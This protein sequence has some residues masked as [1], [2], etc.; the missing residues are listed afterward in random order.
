MSSLIHIVRERFAR[1]SAMHSDHR[2]GLFGVGWSTLAQLVGM[3]LRLGSSLVLTRLLGQEVY[4]LF[5]PA[6]A[7]LMVVELISDLG[8]RP[9]LVRHSEGATPSWL[10]TGWVVTFLRGVCLTVLILGTSQILPGQLDKPDLEIILLVLAVRPMLQ[11]LYNSSLPV[12]YREMDFRAISIIEIAQTVAG[13]VTT[14]T[15]AWA[16]GERTVWAMVGGVFASDIAGLVAGYLLAPAPVRPHWNRGALRE[17]SSFGRAIY[18]NTMV[19]ALWLYFDRIVGLRYVSERDLGPYILAWNLVEVLDR[20][21]NRGCDVYYS[22]LSRA[23]SL[24]T[25]L[26]LH[27]T[28]S[29]IVSRVAMPLFAF[30]I[31]AA[32]FVMLVYPQDKFAPARW[33]LSILIAR[34]MFRAVGQIQFQYLLI[35]GEVYLGTRCYVVAFFFQAGV[36]FALVPRYGVEGIAWTVTLSTLFWAF[37]QNVVFYRRNELG[38]TPLFRTVG[39]ATAGLTVTWMILFGR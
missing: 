20:I 4:G 34:M 30:A 18:V 21:I 13:V 29:G 33:F 27:R 10:G 25:E 15:M 19:M 5:G 28:V 11:S 24:Q 7:V 22:V 3:V 31:I 16:F 6:L 38:F 37:A 32:P 12:L 23:T 9:A 1:R 36:F 17:F 26:G 2:A 39:W 14:I 8:V 35:R